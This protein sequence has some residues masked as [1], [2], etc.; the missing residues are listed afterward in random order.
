MAFHENLLPGTSRDGYVPVPG[1]PG[2]TA[3]LVPAYRLK[4]QVRGE[5]WV[6][7]LYLSKK[8]WHAEYYHPATRTHHDFPNPSSRAQR[9]PRLRWDTAAEALRAVVDHHEASTKTS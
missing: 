5:G 4:Y 8:G 9:P 1:F 7:S 6:A 2:V 3:W